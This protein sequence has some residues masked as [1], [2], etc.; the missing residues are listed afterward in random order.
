MVGVYCQG[1]YCIVLVPH[2][3]LYFNIPRRTSVSM[4]YRAYLGTLVYTLC[5]YMD[6]YS[7]YA[8]KKMET[9]EKEKSKREARKEIPNTSDV[10][11]V[12]EHIENFQWGYSSLPTHLPL[13]K[14]EAGAFIAFVCFL[15]LSYH[16]ISYGTQ[17]TSR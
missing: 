9:S 17:R 3:H 5:V 10:V 12:S 8:W 15:I 6:G 14:R 2:T 4:L 1:M 16:C 11:V 7:V 13:G